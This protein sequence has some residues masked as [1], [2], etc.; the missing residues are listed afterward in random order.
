[1]PVALGDPESGL[2]FPV[3]LEYYLRLR[4]SLRQG[5][6]ELKRVV[7]WLLGSLAIAWALVLPASAGAATVTF[8]YTGAAQDWVVPYGVT[9]ASW[10]IYGAEGMGYDVVAS[11]FRGGDGGRALATISV[12]GGST[13]RVMV[14]GKGGIN[15]GGFNGGGNAQWGG[16]GAT[17]IRIGG[18]AL[19]DR[20]LVA[21]GGGAGNAN[22]VGASDSAFGGTGTGGPNG[23]D[24]TFTGCGTTP[25]T[26]GTQSAGGSI[27]GAL[28]L[29]GAG[30]RS[31]GGG[32]YYG[33]GGGGESGIGS[34]GGGGGGGSSYVGGGTGGTTSAWYEYIDGG[35]TI[36]WESTT[37][38]AVGRLAW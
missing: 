1:M 15:S 14:G 18:T 27:N 24:G 21:G 29:G 23:W 4:R 9:S 22:C 28:G 16:G 8:N 31:G 17:D 32:G 5:V 36:M 25:G 12:T 33:G 7:G 19:T 35:V 37:G 34:T 13:V 11:R 38:W 2:G 26:G 10:D 6:H 3:E 20:V 30:I